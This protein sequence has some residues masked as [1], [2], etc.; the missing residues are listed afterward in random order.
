MFLK[1]K[2]YIGSNS[3]V[4]LH[5]GTLG[6]LLK[7][8]K[9]KFNIIHFKA[10]LHCIS[11]PEKEMD[12]IANSLFPGGYLITGHEISQTEDRIEQLFR[13][14]KIDDKDVE[15]IFKFYFK[16][17]KKIGK[18]FIKRKY[19]AGNSWNACLYFIK[20]RNFRLVKEISNNKL[21][22]K[23]IIRINDILIAIREGT[24]GVFYNGLTKKDRH[25]LYI[26]LLRFA[27]KNKININNPR[28]I[29]AKYKIYIL[30]KSFK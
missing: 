5:L 29:P 17:R 14:K 23:R 3:N 16:L 28:V 11:E 24:F 25:F 15:S 20:K 18:P 13:Y 7:K 10:L 4:I 30:Q 12:L 21:T 6:T 9:I 1:V 2:K 8:E 26:E 19:P 27:E 22:W